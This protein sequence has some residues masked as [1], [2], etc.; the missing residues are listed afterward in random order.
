[1]TGGQRTAE[2]A[3]EEWPQTYG[4]VPAVRKMC[5]AVLRCAC[6]VLVLCLCCACAV[7]VLVLVLCCACAVLVLCLCCACKGPHGKLCKAL[8]RLSSVSSGSKKENPM[9]I[10]NDP[11]QGE[12]LDHS[13]Q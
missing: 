11:K 8:G 4:V 10:S 13:L 1:M 5:A 12:T 9:S 7:L 3:E 2:L 6:A